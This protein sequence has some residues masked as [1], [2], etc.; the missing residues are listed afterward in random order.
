MTPRVQIAA[1]K[2]LERRLKRRPRDEVHRFVG[3]FGT[4]RVEVI[5]AARLPVLP[6]AAICRGDPT[7]PDELLVDNL[8]CHFKSEPGSA[9]TVSRIQTGWLIQSIEHRNGAPPGLVQES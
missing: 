8:R 6:L 2:R 4:V 3:S 9:L 7:S 1:Q 5:Y